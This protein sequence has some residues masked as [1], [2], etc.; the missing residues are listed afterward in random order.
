M[1]F[2]NRNLVAFVTLVLAIALCLSLVPACKKGKTTFDPNNEDQLVEIYAV[3]S[4]GGE[5]A[6]EVIEKYGLNDP[7]TMEKYSMALAERAVTP[8]TWQKFIAKVEVKKAEL[9]K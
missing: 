1:R 4:F 2:L 9:E 7:E 5:Q 6:L 3:T 8:D